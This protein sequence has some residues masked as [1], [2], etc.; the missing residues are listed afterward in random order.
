MFLRLRDREGAREEAVGVQGRVTASHA[1]V[2][3]RPEFPSHLGAGVEPL[4]TTSAN[5]AP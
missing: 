2:P 3:A 4:N 1:R 5:S